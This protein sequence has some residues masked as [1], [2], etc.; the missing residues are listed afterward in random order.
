MERVLT[1]MKRSCWKLLLKLKIK[2]QGYTPPSIY[3]NSQETSH[4][5]YQNT[6]GGPMRKVVFETDNAIFYFELSD[7]FDQVKQYSEKDIYEATELLRTISSTSS[8]VITIELDYFGYIVLDLLGKGKGSVFCKPCQKTYLPI[9]LRSMPVG[10]GKS[11]FEANY[12]EEGGI[13]KRIV[14]NLLYKKKPKIIG[15]KGGEAY[16]CPNGHQLISMITWIS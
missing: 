13:V 15:M 2:N 9:Q 6:K 5:Y 10:F 7:A 12:K 16:A 3:I 1:S 8:K 4:P 14:K 11:P